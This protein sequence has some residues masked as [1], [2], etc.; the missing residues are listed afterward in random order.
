MTGLQLQKNLKATQ[1]LLQGIHE[2]H[3]KEIAQLQSE[4]GEAKLKLGSSEGI[5]QE[6]RSR[7]LRLE[8]Q[9]LSARSSAEV[10]RTQEGIAKRELEITRSEA[11]GLRAELNLIKSAGVQKN[12]E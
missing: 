8:E 10:A 7:N 4:L 3:A 5:V 12:E 6:M 9:L 2:K 11:G 1:E